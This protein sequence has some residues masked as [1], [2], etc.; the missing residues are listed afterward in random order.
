ISWARSAAGA[1]GAARRAFGAARTASSLASG[2]ARGAASAHT[3]QK[4]QQPATAA[5]A[6][7]VVLLV[8]PVWAAVD[9]APHAA[10]IVAAV[11]VDIRAVVALDRCSA[12][13]GDGV[14]GHA[15]WLQPAVHHR[16]H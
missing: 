7:A 15:R 16:R 8:G 9:A 1:A 11:A 10:G 6:A 4:P 2:P 5:V 14:H 12:H 3:H 13:T